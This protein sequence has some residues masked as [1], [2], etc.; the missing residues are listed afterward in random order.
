V[1]EHYLDTVG[2]TGSNP[3]SRTIPSIFFP[4][5]STPTDAVPPAHEELAA[6]MR[7]LDDETPEVRRHVAARL[8]TC[9]GD[10][11][12]WM[13][14]WPGSLTGHEKSILRDLLG[15][16]RRANL[17][18][19]WIVPTGG[20]TAMRED[21][22]ALEASLRLLS[23]FLHDGITM[24]QSLSDALDLL[25]EEAELA[26]TASARQVANHLF[27]GDVLRGNRGNA[28]DPSNMD[29]AWAVANGRSNPLGLGI[30]FILVARR[31][32]MEVEGADFPG[33]FLC[34]VHE[35]GIPLLIDCFDQARPHLQMTLL[36]NP[37][38]TRREKAV[39]RQPMSPGAILLLLMDQLADNLESCGRSDDAGLVCKLRRS[40]G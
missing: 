1:V 2:V 28:R 17:E 27:K 19:E 40:L 3:V 33:H 29:L 22:D 18:R 6:L 34:R 12:E 7:L 5:L 39:I 35:D 26:G 37:E 16:S 25:A 11:S 30:I 23:D 24:R 20:A 21:W 15:A 8:D 31:L 13:A 32:D 14:A 38:L 9:G 36:E 4:V 10:I